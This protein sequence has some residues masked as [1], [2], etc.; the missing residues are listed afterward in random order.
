MIEN[1]NGAEQQWF[2]EFGRASENPETLDRLVAVV[3]DRIV[4]GCAGVARSDASAR[5]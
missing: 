5:S 2:D 4:E 1:D 3:N